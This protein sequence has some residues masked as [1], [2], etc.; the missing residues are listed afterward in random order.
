MK[1]KKLNLLQRILAIIGGIIIIVIAL[2]CGYVL[3]ISVQYYRIEDNYSIEI[4][5]N[6]TSK[7]TIG[8]NYN[9]STYNI[10]FGAYTQDFSFFM[11]S[12]EK[13]NGEK[14]SGT[15]SVAKDKDTVVS[16]TTGA[17]NIISEQNVDFAFFQ[18]VD[19]N[20]TRSH[21]YNQYKH[22]QNNFAN[23]SSSISMNFHSAFLFYP[24]FNPH[25][26][27]D[28]GIVTMSKYNISNAVRRSLP[29]DESFPTKF[30]DLDRCLQITRLPIE[31]SEK[32]LVLINVHLSAYDEGGIIRKQQ[33]ELLNN[34]F[35]EESN[36]GNY[37]VAGGDFNHDIASS[38][39]LWQTNRKQPEWVYVLYNSNLANGYRFV[40]SNNAPTCRSTDGPYVEGESYLVVLDGFICSSNIETVSI[41]NIDTEFK[42]SDHNPSILT[43]KLI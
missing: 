25:G 1:G 10:G 7:V 6:Q 41:N 34:I 32:E 18:E 21:G 17:I 35:E 23:Y 8:Q 31:N 42:Y 28:A 5:N 4:K 39:G 16:N 27:T 38:V 43:F 33:L 9:I 40:S 26:K 13:I 29:I 12:G 37:V 20:A 19:V 11:D 22:I 15:G 2:L 24:I 14:L 3:Y 36:K 30:F